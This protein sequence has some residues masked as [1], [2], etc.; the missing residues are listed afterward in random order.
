MQGRAHRRRGPLNVVHV[1][2]LAAWL[3]LP[4]AAAPW[5]SETVHA[6]DWGTHPPSMTLD[7][8]DRPI[9]AVGEGRLQV[10]RHDGSAWSLETVIDE[11]GYPTSIDWHPSGGLVASYEN[12]LRDMLQIAWLRDGAWEILDI[13]P[14]RW[15]IRDDDRLS[16]VLFD[17]TGAPF[18]VA[19]TGR[20]HTVTVRWTGS[21]WTG[22]HFDHRAPAFA[23]AKTPDGDPAFVLGGREG[24][25]WHHP[26]IVTFHGD[27]EWTELTIDLG[28][29]VHLGGQ[30]SLAFDST[31]RPH[32]AVNGGGVRWTREVAGTWTTE[33][34]GVSGLAHLMIGADDQPVIIAPGNFGSAMT[35]HRPVDGTW[36]QDVLTGRALMSSRALARNS[37][38]E[39]LI[40]HVSHDGEGWPGH[41]GPPTLGYW[42]PSSWRSDVVGSSW[43]AGD[44]LQLVIDRDGR[45]WVAYLDDE[46]ERLT[47][48]HRE[49]ET[50]VKAELRPDAA[51]FAL[52]LD[53]DG[54]TL[55]ALSLDGDVTLVSPT[56][57]QEL[58]L[59]GAIPHDL[60]VSSLGRLAI[61]MTREDQLL[62][63]LET[64]EGEWSFDSFPN[65]SQVLPRIAF[66][67]TDRA[68]LTTDRLA[69][70]QDG[71]AWLAE[72]LGGWTSSDVNLGRSPDG[73]LHVVDF[74]TSSL[75][76]LRTETGTGWEHE[77]IPW[78]RSLSSGLAR[79]SRIGL[80]FSPSGAPLVLAQTDQNQLRGPVFGQRLTSGPEW[81]GG[82]WWLETVGDC[83]GGS[84]HVALALDPGGSPVVAYQNECHG[85]VLIAR[86]PPVMLLRTVATDVDTGW[87]E[88]LL[89]LDSSND[90][91]TSPFPAQIRAP[92]EVTDPLAGGVLSLYL[93]VG[94]DDREVAP[95]LRVSKSEGRAVIRYE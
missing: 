39:L 40:A 62:V 52:G 60:A 23:V 18:L 46:H 85:E 63:G 83:I 81:P 54:E 13:V 15:D 27:D 57:T 77:R 8:L 49:G 4:S 43:A 55:L 29:E 6:N 41:E 36:T 67:A 91:E 94:D 47:L 48:A 11:C 12:R 33:D 45:E 19:R 14:G 92:G 7:E 22:T 3:P 17:A 53:G 69:M 82:S 2:I 84:R 44:G 26:R 25:G 65:P 58:G 87:T 61:A 10:A 88:G 66:D 50:W 86:Q 89:P 79:T 42:T 76:R 51:G 93:A 38:G 32:L 74:W 56:G 34:V 71:G 80:A 21:G 9:L 73:N 78:M 35:I 72:E 28:A 59:P 68:V 64:E 1:C 31:G 5:E 95:L 90:L 37:V 70:R 24:T 30:Q 20:D 75:G 16:S